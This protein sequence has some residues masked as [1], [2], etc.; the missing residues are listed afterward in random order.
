MAR[1]PSIL[2]PPATARQ[3]CV[4]FAVHTRL[5]PPAA[6]MTEQ[7]DG[8]SGMCTVFFTL[9][10]RRDEAGSLAMA[11]RSSVGMESIL[12]PNLL[13][14]SLLK[15]N[16]GDGFGVGHINEHGKVCVVEQGYD[17]TYEQEGSVLGTACMPRS[18]ECGAKLREA[19]EGCSVWIGMKFDA[20]LGFPGEG[21]PT[22][23]EVRRSRRV[24]GLPIEYTPVNV[25]GMP[26]WQPDSDIHADVAAY[27]IPMYLP[28]EDVIRDE[29]V[30]ATYGMNESMNEDGHDVIRTIP[31]AEAATEADENL[32]LE[33]LAYNQAAEAEADRLLAVE[34]RRARLE[35]MIEEIRAQRPL[36]ER[37]CSICMETLGDEDHY[38][39]MCILACHHSHAF[40]ALCVGR[41]FAQQRREGAQP[42][43]PLC[44]GAASPDAESFTLACAKAERARQAYDQFRQ[45]DAADQAGWDAQTPRMMHD[46]L[47][48]GLAPPGPDVLGGWHSID[49]MSVFECTASPCAHLQDVPTSLRID[50][51]RANV[52]VFRYIHMAQSNQDSL[53]VERGLKWYM[54]LHDVLLRG[55]SRGT[56]GSE[57]NASMTRYLEMRFDAWRRG[58]REQLVQWW[59]DDRQRATEQAIRR[60]RS[61]ESDEDKRRRSVMNAINLIHDGELS[62]AM[63]VLH[64]L[65]SAKLSPAVL[66]QLQN[67]HPARTHPV[68]DVLPDRPQSHIRVQLTETF[69][70]LR[71]R[72]GTGPSGRRNEYLRALVGRFDD[73]MADE[74]MPLYDEFATRLVN[75][76]F[77]SWFYSAISI[78][79]MAPLI[80]AR[81]TPE[82]RERGVEPDVRPVSL[83]EVD[84]RAIL[85]HLTSSVSEAAAGELLPQQV[86]VGVPGGISVLIHGIRCT[87]EIHRGFVLVKTDMRNGYNAVSRAVFLR[88]LARCRPLAHLVPLIHALLAAHPLIVIGPLLE[89]LFRQTV[90]GD[91]HEGGAQGMPIMT[92]AFCVAIQ[93]ELIALDAE[94]QPFEGGARAIMDDC[95]A[96]GPPSVVFPALARFARRLR[97]ATDLEMQQAKY[98]CWS[99][100]YDLDTCTFREALGAPVGS[101]MLQD[102]SEARG[103]LVGGVP[104][105]EPAF[106]EATMLE[107]AGG[108]VS[109]IDKTVTELRDSPF[110]A[111]SVIENCCQS[112]FDYQLRHVC[113]SMTVGA[114]ALVDE[115]LIHAA[116][117]IG[118]YEGVLG[119][120]ITL[121]R[122]NLPAR[123]RGCGIRSRVWLAAIAYCACFIE[124]AEM[125]LDIQGPHGTRPGVF[126]GLESIFGQGA[127]EEGGDGFA[128]YISSPMR[129]SSAYEFFTSWKLCQARIQGGGVNGPLD[130]PVE[131]AGRG[132]AEAER[133][134]RTITAQCEQVSRDRL[135]HDMVQLPRM[136]TR[137]Q[138]W[139]AVDRLSSQWVTAW[140]TAT[141]Q[142]TPPEFRE[143]FTTYLGRD[144]PAVRHL[145]GRIIPCSRGDRTSDPGG[146][147]LG[148]ATLA[149]G[150]SFTALH[151]AVA[152][153]LWAIMEG[154]AVRVQQEPTAIF[155]HLIPPNVLLGRDNQGRRKPPGIVPDAMATVELPRAETARGRPQQ[156][157]QESA[158]PHLMDVKT[159]HGGGTLYS[160]A[161]ARDEQSGAV[162]ERAHQ[163]APEYRAHARRLDGAHSAAGSRAIENH[164]LSFGQVRALVFGYTGEASPDV[165]HLVSHVAECMARRQWRLLGAR[166]M[167]EA[168]SFMIAKV[169]R[170]IGMTVV[171]EYAR[172]RL[173][174][175]PFVGMP[176]AAAIRVAE[177]RARVHHPYLG[178]TRAYDFYHFQAMGAARGGL[179]RGG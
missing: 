144:S 54:C 98:A 160:S 46:P 131:E 70:G 127:F 137:R 87:M 2:A 49:K 37:S 145:A 97:D 81:L 139:M 77:P 164:L 18:Y 101:I 114:A 20:T 9:N 36:A 47:Y 109:Y 51:A 107:I 64:S 129:T 178:V 24:Q 143:V 28:W 169:R 58:D 10:M 53:A 40:H 121:R 155:Q 38:G 152:W 89:R 78:M 174:R 93:P 92:T 45:L 179:V 3:E 113:P 42:T 11:A 172:H 66:G 71:R 83:G 165:H 95:Y 5:E 31:S 94:L 6:G 13:V 156:R 79:G 122:F 23:L 30:Q 25:V 112:R 55:P 27:H 126:P 149:D 41:H 21:P 91:S 159:I 123:M 4:D 102:G 150:D 111:W 166:S 115:A 52:E 128:Q 108:I 57:R 15:H 135:H 22:T 117:A 153:E 132:R 157:G 84:L 1:E 133:L 76:E 50:W 105:G 69:I 63:G 7:A 110:E 90:E 67:K 119:D 48:L 171:R 43:C 74:V 32:Y 56:R 85:S 125:F 175:V 142:L 62:R 170:R 130:R 8:D 96:Y 177:A 162:A 124:A 75:V 106:V 72:A 168:R 68:P 176:R 154:A 158:R 73:A 44:R 14:E 147:Q 161:R 148:L 39:P 33:A 118:G 141:Q 26:A 140:P 60:G 16:F 146:L 163:V 65:G 86:A 103:V 116:E 120:A 19:G 29:F 151:D 136:D 35:V 104:I 99:P 12:K 34:E 88:R 173:R 61:E 59:A 82:Q 134:Q 167:E 17:S 138:A 80:K 100:E